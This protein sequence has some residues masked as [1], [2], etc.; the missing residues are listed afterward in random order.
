MQHKCMHMLAC[1]MR[2]TIEITPDQ[3]E[4]LSALA[5]R[6]GIRGFST[7]VQ[8]ALTSYLQD[9]DADEIDLLLSLEGVLS[10]EDEARVRDRINS[11]RA[12]WRA[13]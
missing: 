2:T 5:R 13:G 1:I 12:T 6:R 7:I 4:A 8:E 3:N 10:Q 9:L 11:A